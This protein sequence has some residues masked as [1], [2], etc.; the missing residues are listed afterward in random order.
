[1]WRGARD[2]ALV[3]PFW[4]MNQLMKSDADFDTELSLK[5][6]DGFKLGDVVLHDL[7]EDRPRPV[8]HELKD[9]VLRVPVHT[10]ARA[11]WLLL[12]RSAK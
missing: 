11:A 12:E 5:L 2:G 7:H 4:R 3:V 8:G 9:G 1:M 6:P 10:T